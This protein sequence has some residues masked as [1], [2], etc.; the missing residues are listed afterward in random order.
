MPSSRPSS[1][2]QPKSPDGPQSA[3]SPR[4]PALPHFDDP[5]P[6]ADPPPEPPNIQDAE[7]DNEE[8][9]HSYPESTSE[10]ALLPPP[11]FNPFFNIIED[12][13]SGEHY[14]PYVHYV[15]ADDDPVVVTV[16]AMRSLGL[17]DTQFL[18]QNIPE[19][20]GERSHHEEPDQEH[21]SE[22]QVESPLPPPIPGVKERYL[23]V[24]IAADGHS[25]VDAQ[26][27]SSEWQITNADV[28][29]APSFDQE[30]ADHAY[31]LRID[32]VEI[33]AKIKGRAKPEPGEA[34]L[35]EAMEKA[36]GDVFAAVDGLLRDVEVGLEVA[37]KIMGREIGDDEQGRV[38]LDGQSGEQG[39]RKE[40]ASDVSPG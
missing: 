19:R 21:D 31:M 3:R 32:G 38:E 33:P 18:P 5:P 36:Q 12:A 1:I 9:D 11:N 22:H 17:D 28:R 39:K 35:K 10:H 34:K 40:G 30:S 20:D 37:G 7:L 13:T 16:A 23:I 2:S 15:F 26:S 29:P 27:F 8:D 24:D 4:S 6:Q 25:V 14:H